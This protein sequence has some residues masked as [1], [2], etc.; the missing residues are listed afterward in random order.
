MRKSN[1]L[2]VRELERP[3]RSGLW[4]CVRWVPFA[5]LPFAGSCIMHLEDL[6][7]A[8][9]I[10]PCVLGPCCAT[11]LAVGEEGGF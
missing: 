9:G 7:Q 4:R 10:D 6:L 11:T 3:P 1:H 5:L 2:F 8:L